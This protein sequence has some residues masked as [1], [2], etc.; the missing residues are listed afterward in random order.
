[1]KR[2]DR[3]LFLGLF[4]VFMISGC[5][6]TPKDI[7]SNIPSLDEMPGEWVSAD[8]ADME[9]SIRNF[10]GQALTNR[11][12]NSVSWFV[13][14]P[15]SGGYHTGRLRINGETPEVSSFRWQAWQALRKAEWNGLELESSTRMPI[16]KDGLMWEITITNRSENSQNL[17]LELDMIGFNSQ[18][19]GEWQWWYP[20][21]K[22]DGKTTNRDEEVE[23]V[24]TYFNKDFNS[25]ETTATELVNGKP[26]QKQVTL[27]WPTDREILGSD[28][29]SSALR[30]N[31]LLVNDRET[32]AKTAFQITDLEWEYEVF[33]SG[34]TAQKSVTLNPGESYTIR[35]AMTVASDEKEVAENVSELVHDFDEEFQKIEE[36]WRTRWKDIFHPGN[37]WLSGSFPVLETAD[38][39]AK[40]VYYTGPLTMLY[41]MNTNLPQHEKVFLT[42]GPRWGASITFFWDITEWSTLWAVVDPEMMKEHL[43]SWILID[44]SLHYGKDNISGVGVGNG[45]SA[46]YWAL[47]QMIRSYLT[48]S[49]DYAFLD[50]MID[51]KTVYDHLEDYAM[52]WKRISIYGQDGAQEDIYKLADF[53]DDE[54]NLLEAVPTYKHIVP[55]FNAAYI[56]MMREL[57]DFAELEGDQSKAQQLRNES[58]EMMDR[59]LKLYAGNG[60]WNSLYPNGKTVEVRHSLDFMFLGRYVS[61]DIPEEIKQEM[62]DFLYRELITDHWMRAQSLQD[63]AAEDSDRPDHGPLGAFDGW[64]AGTMDALTQLGYPN[65]ALDFY[66]NIAPVTKEGIWAQAHELWGENKREKNARVRIAQRGWH[67]RESSSGI[68]MS[69]VMLKNFFG[70]YPDGN[71]SVISNQD[72]PDMNGTLYNVKYGESYFD[73]ILKDGDVEMV[74]QDRSSD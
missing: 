60:V 5:Q 14:A 55:S 74:R 66:H 37:Q 25:L 38:S 3:I 63:I 61:Q 42:G 22:M 34:A 31:I 32:S 47:F 7:Y 54:W 67:N 52:N 68:A 48:I 39:L 33:N 35:Y 72:K 9:P 13:S 73:L 20:Y 19:G 43:S 49:K 8:T 4:I 70:F 23:N 10:R 56:W 65:K 29:Y 53:G 51:G 21:P 46:N 6:S 11:D 57:A 17:D 69:Q 50:E 18:Y 16:D 59:L 71:G 30:E 2:P 1:M 41:L 44:P 36:E 26:Q 15:Y 27:T 45:Y 64:P 62:M 12:I 28:K 24:R 58:D 40:R